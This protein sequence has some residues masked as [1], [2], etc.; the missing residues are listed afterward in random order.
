MCEMNTVCT[1]AFWSLPTGVLSS[2]ARPRGTQAGRTLTRL[3]FWALAEL[4][5]AWSGRL[6]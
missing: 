5:D 2:F 6:K 1:S 4:G 3:K